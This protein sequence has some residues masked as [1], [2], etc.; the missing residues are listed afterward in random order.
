MREQYGEILKALGKLVSFRTV[1][2]SPEEDAPFGGEIRR[3]L[4]YVLDLG[5]SMGF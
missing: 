1:E 4:R 2:G 3:A 5:E